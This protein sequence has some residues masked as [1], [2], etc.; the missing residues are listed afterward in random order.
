[1]LFRSGYTPTPDEIE[2]ARSYWVDVE[3]GLLHGPTGP[4]PVGVDWAS[5]VED[6]CSTQ[7]N[8]GVRSGEWFPGARV[9]AVLESA[10]HQASIGHNPDGSN[11][12]NDKRRAFLTEQIA[13]LQRELDSLE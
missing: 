8:Q 2:I 10:Y 3:Q 13:R 6:E 9:Q 7:L 5:W 4:L 12:G 11:P 1:M